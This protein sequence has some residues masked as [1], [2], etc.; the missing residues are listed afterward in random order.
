MKRAIWSW[1]D[2]GHIL[3]DHTVSIFAAR[4]REGAIANGH[5]QVV[6]PAACGGG[7]VVVAKGSANPNGEGREP[8]LAAIMPIVEQHLAHGGVGERRARRE[9]HREPR[10]GAS[11]YLCV[12]K[13]HIV[14]VN[15]ICRHV[16][17]IRG[18]HGRRHAR[19]LWKG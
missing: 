19:Q 7:R 14:I 12:A 13:V 8:I 4:D 10:V 15:A 9:L 3:T 18:A 16:W 17:C 5:S 11:P 2:Y 6:Q 1:Q